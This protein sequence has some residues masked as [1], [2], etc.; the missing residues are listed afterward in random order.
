MNRGQDAFAA[1]KVGLYIDG[2]FRISKFVKAEGLNFLF[3]NYQAIMGKDIIFLLSGQ[4][5]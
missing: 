4:M 3:L 1:G 2:S 5:L